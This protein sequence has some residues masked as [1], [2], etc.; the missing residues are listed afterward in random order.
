[1]SAKDSQLAV[2]RIRIQESDQ[3]LRE[4]KQKLGRFQNENERILRDHSDSSGIQNQV[5]E[6][7]RVRLQEAVLSLKHEQEAHQQ[8]RTE[9][10]ER[11]SKLESEQ[12][13]MAETVK[14]LQKNIVEERRNANGCTNKLKVSENKLSSAN[15]EF[16][17]YKEKAG[18]ILQAK[19]KVIASLKEGK[20][21][22]G[23]SSGITGAEYEAMC[24]ERD[25]LRDEL[26]QVKYGMEQL[27]VD[28]QELE[29][30]LQSESETAEEQTEHL[31]SLLDE[32]KR[33]KEEANH[34]VLKTREEL[35]TLSDN[36]Y[37]Q[38]TTLIAQ[39]Q[40]REGEIEKL[41]S[42]LLAKS[43]STTSEAEL[44]KRVRA[45]TENLIQKQTVIEALSTEKS[46]LVLQLERLEMQYKDIQRSTSRVSVPTTFEENEEGG[47]VR[48]ITSIMPS[49]ITES[50][51]VH[52]AVNEIDKF[53]I[54]LGVFL[55]RY[56]IARLM[57]IL[58]MILLHL[59][60]FIVLLTY[61]PEIHSNSPAGPMPNN[62]HS[63]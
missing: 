58:Y 2:L 55:R 9:S 32:E 46:S 50:A 48:P 34:D 26:H 21:I 31:Q 14:A 38:K 18:R 57:L 36:H 11:Q 47:R 42:Q 52:K 15:Q 22:V 60:V 61:Q 12:R 49:Q 10:S 19:E 30:Q 40:E 63:K 6:D 27:K 1:M 43:Y 20:A 51:K 39:I 41:K 24:Q 44:E 16:R 37:R 33:L 25:V 29:Q 35:Q 3:E 62:P 56:P 45:L 7:L 8:S 13:S 59:W 28:V 5:L 54:R 53:S 4:T 17:D 23:D